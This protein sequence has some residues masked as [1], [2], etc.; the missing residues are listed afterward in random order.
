MISLYKPYMPE[1]LPEIDPILHG[2]ALA[3]GKW[4][5]K[6]EGAIKDFIGCQEDVLVVNS[7]TAALQVVLST[8]DIKSDDEIIA[9]PQCCMAST[10][11]LVTYGARVVWADIDP[12]RGT[13]CPQSVESKITSKTKVIFHNHHCGYPGYIDE[14]N[15]IGRR[16]GLIV[17]DDCIES[18][19]SAYKGKI[20][21]NLG[22]DVTV[23]S[24]QTVRLPNTIDGGGI[25]FKNR[26]LYERAFKIR[27]LGVD[28][29]TFRDSLG[30]INPLSD[31]SIHGYGVTMNEISSY[32]GSC[33]ILDLPDLF[34]RQ[35]ENAEFWKKEI[36][37][38]YSH[39]SLLNTE[40]CEPNYWVFGTLSDDKLSVL[41]H[42]RELGYSA[43]GVH[44][45]NSYYSIFGQ[46]DELP[47][48][49]EFYSRF[50][51]L[52]CGW[53]FKNEKCANV[54]A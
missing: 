30:E 48:V 49:K 28:R 35:R 14:I 45:P 46:Q 12:K 51:A 19:G 42:F 2:G 17:I 50:L 27:D 47:G 53:W 24:F 40:N 41:K 6:F 15:E 18:F 1:L 34:A 52:P 29:S 36:S 16:Y 5:R 9:S 43:S 23:F 32:I 37:E 10:Q 11:P 20:L 26:D 4:G 21:G 44:I 22:T 13:L 25:I 39:L 7:F 33:Q 8:L 31:V 54:F 3:Y 38:K